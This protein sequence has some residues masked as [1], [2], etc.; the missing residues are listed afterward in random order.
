V[1]AEWLV[2][3]QPQLARLTACRLQT[4]ACA[5][6]AVEL[7]PDA[8]Y[9]WA[10]GARSLYVRVREAGKLGVAVH[11]IATGERRTI[12][13]LAP[14]GAGTSIAPAPDDSALLIAREEGPTVDLMLAR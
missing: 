8:L 9:H 5:P 11:D 14:S 4:L 6:L 13:P 12:L 3:A 7:E 2:F 1:N 10:L